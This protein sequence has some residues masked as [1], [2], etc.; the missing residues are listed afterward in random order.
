MKLKM[1][2]HRKQSKNVGHHY[3]HWAGRSPDDP[4]HS[5]WFWNDGRLSIG[6]ANIWVVFLDEGLDKGEGLFQS[7]SIPGARVQYPGTQGDVRQQVWVA[8]DLVQ[9]IQHGLHTMDPLLLLNFPT[10]NTSGAPGMHRKKPSQS[11]VTLD[12]YGMSS[13]GGGRGFWSKSHH[14]YPHDVNQG[15][16]VLSGCPADPAVMA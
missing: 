1:I 16:H 12:L 10:W 7:I 3:G 11:D 6:T 4:Y 5:L 14:H 2:P 9:R 13:W 15:A 8:V